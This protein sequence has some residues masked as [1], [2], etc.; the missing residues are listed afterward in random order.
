MASLLGGVYFPL[1]PPNPPT[2]PDI[3]LCHP[4]YGYDLPTHDCI[5]AA[6]LLPLV[7]TPIQVVSQSQPFNFPLTYSYGE[8][9][10]TVRWAYPHPSSPEGHFS[11]IPTAF[12]TVASWLIFSCVEAAGL[13]GFGTIGL[14]NMIRWVSRDATSDVA[15]ST[16]T[17]PA[18][19]TFFTV[20]VTGRDPSNTFDPGFNDPAVA[21]ALSDGAFA[22]GERNRAGVFTMTGRMMQRVANSAIARPW[23]SLLEPR[24][25]GSNNDIPASQMVYACDAKLGAPSPTDCAQ[26][27]YSGLGPPSDTFTIGPGSATKF[28][29][30][31]TCHA[32]I[33]AVATITL[34]WAQISAGLNTLIDT[35]VEHPLR[36]SQGGRAFYGGPSKTMGRKRATTAVTGINALPPSV[37]ISLSAG[38]GHG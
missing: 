36:G 6:S 28:L 20:S 11:V 8:C 5:E 16:G 17:W 9:V 23:W 13:G 18:N 12:R 4:F 19:S 35:C 32:A 26:L 33:T 10:V 34:T 25:R 7:H 2:P 27:A 30:F 24:T 31:K 15:I 3:H 22:G 38:N 37:N 1:E 21:E 29:S 14:Q